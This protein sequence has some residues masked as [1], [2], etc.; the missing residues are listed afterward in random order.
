MKINPS[1]LGKKAN[2]DLQFIGREAERL[3]FHV[4]LVGGVVRDLLLKQPNTDLDVVVEGDAIELAKVVA[5]LF[6]AKVTV[7]EQ[8]GTATLNLSDG[9]LL[10]FATARSEHY[11][12]PGAL[13]VVKAG[14]IKDDLSR[15]DFSINALAIMLNPQS[16]GELQ[17]FYGGRVDVQKKK[18]HIL[19]DKSF[20]DDPTRILRAVRFQ[21]RFDFTFGK[22]TLRLLKSALKQHVYLTV[23]SPRYFAEF[24]KFFAEKT[25]SLGLKRLSALGGLSF[26]QPHFTLPVKTL[27][28]V[29]KTI[30]TL[31]KKVFFKS[32]D[33]STV[34]LLAFFSRSSEEEI[35][36]FAKKFHLTGKELMSLQGL[37][38]LADIIHKLRTPRLKPSQIYE[39]LDPVDLEI[40][41]FIRSV[42]SV[43]IV[44]SRIEDFLQKWRLVSLEITGNDLKHL[45]IKPGRE[46]GALLHTLLLNKVDEKLKNRCDE[47][48][49]AQRLGFK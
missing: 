32:Y 3:G 18:I 22:E 30:A 21:S 2:S 34:Y 35:I 45:G 24:R 7:Y 25:P 48:Q 29:E 10:D 42:T 8:F 23:K 19:H 16:F 39:I 15:R 5:V 40:I 43:T 26:V 31:K 11:P 9:T 12:E 33:W 44:A 46:M 41:T 20:V 28:K 47:I 6:K 13:P 36:R 17:D 37:S 38:E 14:L 49:L 1:V 27:G 4:Y